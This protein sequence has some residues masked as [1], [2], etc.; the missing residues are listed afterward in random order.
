MISYFYVQLHMEFEKRI[1]LLENESLVKPTANPESEGKTVENNFKS[2]PNELN[3]HEKISQRYVHRLCFLRVGC[4]AVFCF[5]VQ[6][7][8]QQ[9]TMFKV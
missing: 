8:R 2:T 9:H 7:K 4:V 5:E 3:R 1:K 6:S